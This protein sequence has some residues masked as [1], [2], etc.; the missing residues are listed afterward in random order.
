[1][2]LKLTNILKEIQNDVL[3][4]YHGTNLKNANSLLRDKKNKF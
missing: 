1:M 3:Y 4:F 2:E